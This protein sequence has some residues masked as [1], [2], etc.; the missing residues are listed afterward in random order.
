MDGGDDQ[1]EGVHPGECI[2]RLQVGDA[3]RRIALTV[4][5]H[6]TRGGIHEVR[7]GRLVAQGAGLSVARDRAVDDAGIHRSH[8]SVVDAVACHHAGHEILDQYVALA[9]EVEHHRARLGMR[10]VDGDALLAGVEANEIAALVGAAL[11]QLQVERARVVAMHRA[12]DLNDARA[13]ICHEA[14]AVRPGEHAREVQYRE[15]SQHG[16]DSNDPRRPVGTIAT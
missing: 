3:R 10:E 13:K 11:L 16:G 14:R 15:V 2:G 7:K 6:R 9:G 5:I 12:L 8:R 4:G 1:A